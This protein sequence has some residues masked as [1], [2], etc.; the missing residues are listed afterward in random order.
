MEAKLRDRHRVVGG[1]LELLEFLGI[2]MR[3][4]TVWPTGLKIFL[5]YG[6]EAEVYINVTYFIPR[7]VLRH[8]PPGEPCT[9]TLPY[10]TL[11]TS[12][13]YYGA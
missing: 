1:G 13:S 11:S 7:V 10:N 5:S 2:P 4:C 12:T 6:Q 8:P 9:Y 3:V